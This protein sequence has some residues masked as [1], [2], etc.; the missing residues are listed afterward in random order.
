[1]KTPILNQRDRLEITKEMIEAGASEL[2]EYAA[3]MANA[4]E[5]VIRVFFAML[6]AQ[7]ALAD[8]RHQQERLA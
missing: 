3:D 1:M 7:G 2:I 4:D 5:T 8:A 6:S